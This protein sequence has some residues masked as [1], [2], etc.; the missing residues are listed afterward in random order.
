[1]I[2]VSRAELEDALLLSD[3]LNDEDSVQRVRTSPGGD[4]AHTHVLGLT[5]AHAQQLLAG[6]SSGSIPTSPPSNDPTFT[7]HT[8]FYS[9][10]PCEGL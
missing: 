2:W 8:H 10:V 6:E 9:L 3:D 4:D 7:G 5:K 1:L